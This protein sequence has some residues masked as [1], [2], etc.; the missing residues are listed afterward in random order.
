MTF[1]YT[2]VVYT[3][4]KSFSPPPPA[5]FNAIIICLVAVYDDHCPRAA[6]AQIAYVA[7]VV[8]S[9]TP[10]TRVDVR[11]S[12]LLLLLLLLLLCVVM[13]CSVTTT[14]VKG[15]G[16]DCK[17]TFRGQTTARTMRFAMTYTYRGNDTV[18]F[19]QKQKLPTLR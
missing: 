14:L 5:V 11:Y 19:G 6:V 16:V 18:R 3:A 4:D 2:L 8:R 15:V 12:I 1:K 17:M 13:T 9:C 10:P 7:I